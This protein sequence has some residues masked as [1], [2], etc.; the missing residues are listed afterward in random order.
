MTEPEKQRIRKV[1]S[2]NAE[3]YQKYQLGRLYERKGRSRED[4]E[5]AIQLYQES[6]ALDHIEVLLSNTGAYSAPLLKLD[7][8]WESVWDH[9]EFIRLTDLYKT[10]R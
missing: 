2:T 9:P 6:A 5:M 10:Q 3:A 8:R 7:P 1:Y 4:T